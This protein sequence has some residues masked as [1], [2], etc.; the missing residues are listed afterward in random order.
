VFSRL[1][2]RSRRAPA[3]RAPCSASRGTRHDSQR[4]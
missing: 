3:N 1:R 2:P 4:T